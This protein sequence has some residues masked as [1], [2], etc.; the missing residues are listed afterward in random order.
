M[1]WV[2][3][4]VCPSGR[5][6]SATR[7]AG[8]VHVGGNTPKGAEPGNSS[9]TTLQSAVVAGVLL[10]QATD[11]PADGFARK[12][13]FLATPSCAKR[14]SCSWYVVCQSVPPELTARLAEFD[15]AG[16]MLVSSVSIRALHQ[17]FQSQRVPATIGPA[18]SGSI[19]MPVVPLPP[20]PKAPVLP[21]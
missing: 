6:F 20:V 16:Q 10:L 8:V 3:S 5:P 7:P 11:C 15:S 18:P 2:N 19:A 17:A 1:I 9:Q 14:G 4:Y 13:R 21:M 12:Q